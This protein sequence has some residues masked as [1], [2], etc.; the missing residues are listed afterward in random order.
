MHK[1]EVKRQYASVR[2]SGDSHMPQMPKFFMSDFN[3][4]AVL[5][6]SSSQM[7]VAVIDDL[8]VIR[9]SDSTSLLSTGPTAD[10]VHP[11]QPGLKSQGRQVPGQSRGFQAKPGRNITES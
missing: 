2:V 6:S 3:V 4:F 8:L 9:P 10:T 1:V 5:D 7:D 11:S